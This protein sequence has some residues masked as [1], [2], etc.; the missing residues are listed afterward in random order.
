MR[1]P[2][3]PEIF[4]GFRDMDCTFAILVE[5]GWKSVRNWLQQ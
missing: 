1:R 2:Q 4:V 3:A 5:T